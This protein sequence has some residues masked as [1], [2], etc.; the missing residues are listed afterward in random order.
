MML[1][2]VYLIVLLVLLAFVPGNAQESKAVLK[3]IALQFVEGADEQNPELLKNIMEPKA[4]QYV[5]IGGQ[6]STF[7]TEQYIQMVREK[8]L[9]G[10]ARK[11]TYKHAEF[12][13]ENL[14][15]VV[16]NAV[17]SELDFL[18]QLAMARSKNGKWEIVGITAEIKKV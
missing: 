4:M 6:F 15:V 13:G 8:K 12:L 17:S 3:K 14:A 9:G 18:Y 2:N 5:L 11:V 1:K 16:L 7:T 10:K